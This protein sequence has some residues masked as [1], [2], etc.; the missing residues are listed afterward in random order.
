MLKIP[1][2]EIDRFSRLWEQL[3][4]EAVHTSAK[5]IKSCQALRCIIYA[6]LDSNGPVL[7]S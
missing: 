1:S 4:D 5:L 7:N 6:L 2:N 3:N